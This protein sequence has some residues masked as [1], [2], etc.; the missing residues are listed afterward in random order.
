MNRENCLDC[1]DPKCSLAISSAILW[2]EF[3]RLTFAIM[4][5]VDETDLRYRLLFTGGVAATFGLNPISNP[6][7]YLQICVPDFSN[8]FNVSC[9]SP[10]RNQVASILLLNGEF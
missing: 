8:S 9:A 10:N 1:L 5:V 2:K 6:G 3:W 4:I 7:S